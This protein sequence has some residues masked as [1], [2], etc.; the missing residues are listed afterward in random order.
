MAMTG[1]QAYALAKKYVKETVEGGGAVV[2]KN[3]VI[4][5]KKEIE[6]GT[7]IVFGYTLDDGTEKTETLDVMDGKDGLDGVSPIITENA[8][9]TDDVYKLDIT[10]VSETKT[11][12]NLKGKNGQ[13]GFSPSIVPD[14]ANDDE[15]YKL[16]I[17]DGNGTITTVNLI[18]K[19]GIQGIQG[20][21]GKEG[22]EGKQGIQGIQG[23]QGDPFLIYKEYDSLDDFDMSDFISPGQMFGVKPS[24]EGGTYD[25][26]RFA[27]EDEE[28]MYTFITSLTAGESIKGEQGIQGEQGRD[29]QDG[30][31]GTTYTPTIGTVTTGHD[32]GASVE[33]NENEKTAVFS[34]T[35]PDFAIKA[36]TGCDI[37]LN[38]DPIDYVMTL[39][40]KNTEGAVLASRSVDFPLESMVVGV[41]YDETTGE[42]TLKLQNGETTPPIKI[43][44]IVDGLVKD[45]FTIAGIDMKDDITADELR[46]ALS[47]HADFV[48]TT[49]EFEQAKKNGEIKDGMII[50]ITDDYEDVGSSGGGGGGVGTTN[51]NDLDNLPQVNGVT[52]KG[53]KTSDDLKLIGEDELEDIDFSGYF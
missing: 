22:K 35:F 31:D 16:I 15:T 46:T 19:Q 33:V 43:S 28:P 32:V 20:E 34:F 13:D 11:T 26:Y 49:A 37:S 7:R 3:V 36:S 52:L 51:Y 30:K 45:T 24:E 50:Y 40:L 12:P 8:G 47:V 29:G 44:Q 6:G 25:V 18:G 23:I 42:L 14:P 48:G 39:E 5:E 53:N 4:K 10:D 21:E 41:E 38:V 9:N 27:G 17:T 2:G 1:E